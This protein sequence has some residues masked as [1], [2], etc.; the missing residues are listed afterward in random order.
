M[1][2]PGPE[3]DRYFDRN[4]ANWDE[5][6]P[7]H[8]ASDSY[9]VPGFLRGEK[10]LTRIER[11]EVG[12]VRGKRLLHLQCHFGMDTLSWARLGASVTGLDL[13]PA[14]IEAARDL[15]VRARV[16]DARFVEANVYDAPEALGH[17]TFDIVYTG[18]GALNWL[19]DVKT[20]ARAAAA[21]VA[22]GGFLYILECHPVLWSLDNAPQ[23]QP[24]AGPG[25]EYRLRYPYFE[26]AEPGY[27]AEDA[28]TYTDGPPLT[29]SP[30][31]YEWNHG[32]GETI[33]AL[34]QAG[35]RLDFVHEHREVPW[36]ALPWMVPGPDP[37]TWV[38]PG[39]NERVPLAYSLRATK[40]A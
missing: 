27:V 16:E 23:E 21:C 25:P 38:L 12:D 8:A 13:S 4:R 31:S 6:V 17:D 26:T 39:H 30:V 24:E 14:A 9:D 29:R 32:L 1:N 20:W 36:Q 37:R 34:L 40:P 2:R 19:P 18:I 11:E 7:I 33:D 28:R 10:Q 22:P 3:Y 35:L 15:A 5:R